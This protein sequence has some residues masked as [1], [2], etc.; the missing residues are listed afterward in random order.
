VTLDSSDTP[1]SIKEPIR[2]HTFADLFQYLRLRAGLTTYELARR[3]QYSQ[4]SIQANETTL[5]NPTLKTL[6]RYIQRLGLELHITNAGI[7][8]HDPKT[9]TTIVH[10]WL[11]ELD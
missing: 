7:S 6:L 11:V 8:I 1:P 5:R 10:N 4:H 3:I 9:G 2:P